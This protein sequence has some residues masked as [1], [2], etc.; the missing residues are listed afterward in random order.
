MDKK[1][2]EI[3][4]KVESNLY[5]FLYNTDERYIDNLVIR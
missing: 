1:Y 3:I 5:G 2:Q 4:Q